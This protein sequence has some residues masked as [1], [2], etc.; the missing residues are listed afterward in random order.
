MRTKWCIYTVEY[1]SASKNEGNPAMYNNVD[2][3]GDSMLS[4]KTQTQ[5]E[6]ILHDLTCLW[7]LKQWDRWKQGVKERHFLIPKL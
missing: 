5:K 4:E 1:Y 6:K 3:P 2:E 7:N